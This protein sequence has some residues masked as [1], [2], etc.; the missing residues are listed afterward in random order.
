MICSEARSGSEFL[1]GLL[2]STD[3]L[4]KPRE[5]LARPRLRRE[6]GRDSD[7]AVRKLTEAYSTPNGVYALKVFSGQLDLMPRTNWV[8][9]L[10]NLKFVHLE[11]RDLLGQAISYSRAAQTGQF[12]ARAPRLREPRYSR[13]HIAYLLQLT[14]AGHARWRAYFAR[15]GIEPLHLY[16][17]DIVADPTGAVRA[18]AGHVGVEGELEPD[19]SKLHVRVQR[20]ELSDAWRARFLAEAGGLNRTDSLLSSGLRLRLSQMKTRLWRPSGQRARNP[21]D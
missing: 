8:D 16:Y 15:N 6:F 13:R 18:V 4:G 1:R 10:P 3:R 21:W 11:R 17:E 20:D 19:L 9:R 12:G 5:L 2:T 7:A 14:A